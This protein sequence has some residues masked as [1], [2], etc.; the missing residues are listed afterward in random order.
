[1]FYRTAVGCVYH[2]SQSSTSSNGAEGELC[3]DG[4]ELLLSCCGTL[5]FAGTGLQ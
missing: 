5:P 3:R 1:M 2:F 4:N